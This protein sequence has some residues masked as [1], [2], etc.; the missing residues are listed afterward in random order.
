MSHTHLAWLQAIGA[1]TYLHSL[2]RQT[3]WTQTESKAPE[4]Q[5]KALSGPPWNPA[6]VN[7]TRQLEVDEEPS[8]S[9]GDSRD[10][11][12]LLLKVGEDVRL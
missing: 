8:T 9:Y 5:Q 6:R 4:A 11:T 2:P 12:S 7:S 1:K 3:L 10:P